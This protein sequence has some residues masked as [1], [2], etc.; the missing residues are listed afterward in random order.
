MTCGQ[1]IVKG[2]LVPHVVDSRTGATVIA[3]GWVKRL[4]AA[5]FPSFGYFGLGL[6]L[7]G[8]NQWRLRR[9]RTNLR[10]QKTATSSN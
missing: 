1:Y 9:G 10:E 6:V 3:T 2:W 4:A 8:I 7:L 5:P